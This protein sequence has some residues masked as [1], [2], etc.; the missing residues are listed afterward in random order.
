[1]GKKN[2]KKTSSVK[3]IV[4]KFEALLN[5]HFDAESVVDESLSA[6]E[7]VKTLNECLRTFDFAAQVLIKNYADILD[8]CEMFGEKVRKE[9]EKLK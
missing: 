4:S 9:E 6:E 5:K 1:M 7:N 3:N 2:K 8:Y